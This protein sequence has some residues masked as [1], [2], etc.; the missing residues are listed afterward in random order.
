MKLIYAAGTVEEKVSVS[1]NSK[2]DN[3]LALN[4]G[5]LMETDLF[6]L[7]KGDNSE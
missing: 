6:G 4:D 2:I 3:I 1:V 7:L 5:D